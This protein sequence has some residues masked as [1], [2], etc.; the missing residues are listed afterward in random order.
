MQ[1][2][3]IFIINVHFCLRIVS[4]RFRSVTVKWVY[5]C[6]CRF[7]SV[8]VTRVYICNCRFQ[9]VTVT[10]VYT[11]NCRL[12]YISVWYLWF[13]TF[14]TGEE[15]GKGKVLFLVKNKIAWQLL[16]FLGLPSFSHISARLGLVTS[17]CK[18][19]WSGQMRNTWGKYLTTIEFAVTS[20]S[21]GKH[22]YKFPLTLFSHLHYFLWLTLTVYTSLF[23]WL[24]VYTSMFNIFQ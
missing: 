5:T 11:C 24:T 12:Q 23:L 6:N 2:P 14:H 17:I 1:I 20:F 19:Y 9:S 16:C 18:P 22:F 8:I 13:Y 21:F 3:L 4:C 15:K 10:W 7:Q